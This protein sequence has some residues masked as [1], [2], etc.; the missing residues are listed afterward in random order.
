MY[1]HMFR[2]VLHFSK[3]ISATKTVTTHLNMWGGQTLGKP[4]RRLYDKCIFAGISVG[5]GGW[6]VIGKCAIARVFW[7]VILYVH[8]LHFSTLQVWR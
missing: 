3:E 2:Q 7:P 4:W 1:L 5:S 6:P 8:V